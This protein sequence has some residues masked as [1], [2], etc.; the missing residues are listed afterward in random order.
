[1]CAKGLARRTGIASEADICDTSAVVA[2]ASSCCL[3]L[4]RRS[5]TYPGR[6][7]WAWNAHQPLGT[8]DWVSYWSTTRLHQALG[9]RTPVEDEASNSHPETT[10]PVSV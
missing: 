1:M 10:A 5:F 9:Y 7:K 8:L 2:L 4:N 6:D 3:A